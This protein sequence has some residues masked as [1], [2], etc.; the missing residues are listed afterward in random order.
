MTDD[1]KLFGRVL[2]LRCFPRLADSVFKVALIVVLSACSAAPVQLSDSELEQRTT[3][4]LDSLFAKYPPVQQEITLGEA[5]AR[6]LLFNLDDR[7]Q[8]LKIAVEQKAR[9]LDRIDL[10][11]KLALEAGYSGVSKNLASF[12][13]NTVT[14]IRSTQPTV[15]MEDESAQASLSLAWNILDFGVSYVRSQ[16]RADRILI[17]EAQRRQTMQNVLADV[18]A[19][20]WR[21]YAAQQW[22]Q[23]VEKLLTDLQ[24]GLENS[25]RAGDSGAVTK[26][27][28]LR[29][30]SS[31]LETMGDL[32]VVKRRLAG[33]KNELA[34]LMNL[35]PGESY[36]LSLDK[37]VEEQIEKER[38]SGFAGISLSK[39]QIEKLEEKA[40]T[41]RPELEIA[42]YNVRIKRR[43][44]KRSML[45]M[46]P[47]VDLSLD[48]Y[49]DGN[50]FK[51]Y[52]Q[53][54]RLGLNVGYDLFNLLKWPA[55]K[56]QMQNEVLLEEEKRKALAMAA[57][58]QLHVGLAQHGLSQRRLSYADRLA[59]VDE[60]IFTENSNQLRV[61][62]VR[63]NKVLQSRLN[64]VESGLT[65]DWLFAERQRAADQ[66]YIALG[67]SL[68][69]PVPQSTVDGSNPEL[70][71]QELSQAMGLRTHRLHDLEQVMAVYGAGR[72]LEQELLK[73]EGSALPE[74]HSVSKK[75]KLKAQL[76]DPEIPSKKVGTAV[77][78]NED[79]TKSK[80]L[81]CVHTAYLPSARSAQRYI[82][83]NSNQTSEDL[84][85]YATGKGFIVRTLPLNFD[86]AYD[87]RAE[88]R[89]TFSADAYIVNCTHLANSVRQND[90]SASASASASVELVVDP[91][92]SVEEKNGRQL[93]SAESELSGRKSTR[94]NSALVKR[95]D[96]KKSKDLWCVHTAYLSSAKSAQRYIER[97]SNQ[98]SEDLVIYATGK[99]FIVR[100]LPLN[101]DDAYVF[102]T[103]ARASFSIDAFI[104]K[105]G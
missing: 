84:V 86:D 4:V 18:R 102:R 28:A 19:A 54:T 60:K 5:M 103:Q 39:L 72:D 13:K 52:D 66:L 11:P 100:T 77:P 94:A 92:V 22:D 1:S 93:N 50:D 3:E 17:A 104:R 47:S 45:S 74:V 27:E 44:M 95:M 36:R 7:V 37:R 29:V 32:M 87:Y 99:G 105:C 65:R 51:R 55:Q 9:D 31:L 40:L 10:L 63:P 49:Y 67:I 2:V 88:A 23:T 71:L 62:A 38:K 70:K 61:G 59:R 83:R 64:F 35:R 8:L 48:A 12:N 89:S 68:A 97:N 41:L 79:D 6:A 82:E 34:G 90:A 57:L 58:T 91:P 76:T 80:D 85:I 56:R 43:E 26:E 101:F 73:P 53:Y 69:Q 16:Q 30:Q 75:A 25:R 78:K 33:A 96:S 98:T 14:E 81:W 42:D 21:A 20:F 24:V 15:S 46:L